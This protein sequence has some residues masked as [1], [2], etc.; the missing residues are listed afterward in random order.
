MLL[1]GRLTVAGGLFQVLSVGCDVKGLDGFELKAVAP[2]PVEK[3]KSGSEVS[4]AGV[5]ILDVIGK[6]RGKAF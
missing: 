3:A 6:E 1:D 5:F 4:F 2:T